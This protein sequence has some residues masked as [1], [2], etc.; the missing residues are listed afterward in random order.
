MQTGCADLT[1]DCKHPFI[2]MTIIETPEAEI[3]VGRQDFN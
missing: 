2:K 1:Q 3:R